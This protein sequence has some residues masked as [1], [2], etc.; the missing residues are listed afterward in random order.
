[1]G[2]AGDR[3]G[4]RRRRVAA[5]SWRQK[6]RAQLAQLINFQRRSR[7]LDRSARELG[8]AIGQAVRWTYPRKGARNRSRRWIGEARASKG[9]RG[10]RLSGSRRIPSSQPRRTWRPRPPRRRP[11]PPRSRGA[12]RPLRRACRRPSWLTVLCVWCGDEG[13]VCCAGA[14]G[15]AGRLGLRS[16]I[17]QLGFSLSRRFGSFSDRWPFSGKNVR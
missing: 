17:V 5:R 9:S 12:P 15:C 1:V 4:R 13:D 14:L 7:A 10:S 11:P 16:W 3:I 8:S 2:Q 6:R